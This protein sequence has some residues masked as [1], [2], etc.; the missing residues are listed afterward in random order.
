MNSATKFNPNRQ[1]VRFDEDGL[2]GAQGFRLCVSRLG[3]VG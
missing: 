1:C 2:A 3:G